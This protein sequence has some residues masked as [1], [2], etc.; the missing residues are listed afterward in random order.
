MMWGH[1]FENGFGFGGFGW[2]GMLFGG[3]MMLLFW[4][5]LFALLFFAV[6]SFAQPSS[7]H[8]TSVSTLARTS[9]RNALEIVK[10]RYA[11]GELTKEEYD[12]LRQDLTA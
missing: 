2:L 9:D 5:G 10:E 7:N 11:R 3:L 4:G 6:R 1:G 8:G 12:N